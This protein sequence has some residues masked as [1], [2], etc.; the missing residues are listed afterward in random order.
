MCFVVKLKPKNL[1]RIA[2]MDYGYMPE[3]DLL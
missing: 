2:K 3:G 1:N